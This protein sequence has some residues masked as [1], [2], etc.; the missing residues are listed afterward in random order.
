MAE[1]SW[2]FNAEETL[3]GEFDREYLAEDFAKYFSLF[4]SNGVFPNPSTGLQVI[5]ANTPNMT[6]TLKPGYA[7]INGYAYENTADY[8]FDI[9]T[10]DGVLNRIDSIFI[11]FYLQDRTIKAYKAVGKASSV[12]SAP[13]LT[14]TADYWDLCVARIAVNAG[15]TSITQSAITDT[16]LS[17]DLCGIVHSVIDHIDTE[18]LYKQIQ[19]DLKEFKEVSQAEFDAWFE[20]INKRLEDGSATALQKQIDTINNGAMFMEDYNPKMDG[21]IPIE[22]GGTGADTVA[23]AKENLGLDQVENTADSTKAVKSAQIASKMGY[24]EVYNQAEIRGYSGTPDSQDGGI[25]L[26]A[27]YKN[28]CVNVGINNRGA[29][30][31]NL[32]QAATRTTELAVKQMNNISGLFS[33]TYIVLYPGGFTSENSIVAGIKYKSYSTGNSW[34]SSLVLPGTDYILSPEYVS[35]G[36]RLALRS[37]QNGHIVEEVGGSGITK[38]VISARILFKKIF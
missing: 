6:V 31:V 33:G 21:M 2:F 16:R 23:Q 35:N 7:F 4:I 5:A 38:E 11:R 30:G 25:F 29:V 8:V 20:A 37:S 19:T 32:A 22:H 15:A 28:G 3:E 36:I 12:A 13:E 9:D 24:G 34:T 26:Q 17:T 10:A 14:R 18:T 1:K 27:D